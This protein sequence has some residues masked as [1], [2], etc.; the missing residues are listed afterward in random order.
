MSTERLFVEGIEDTNG[1][2][3]VPDPA[4]ADAIL[5]RLE[6][7]FE[8][9]RGTIIGEYFHGGTLVFPPQTIKRLAA[10]AAQAPLYMSVFLE[11]PA[12]IGP[13]V[14]LGATVIG[15]FGASDGVVLDAFRGR[16][17][18]SGRLPFDIPSSMEAAE[19]S[20][21]DVPFDTAA[22]GFHTGFGLT[23]GKRT[24]DPGSLV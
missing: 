12:I 24:A 15:E 7:L 9:G 13:P 4:D 10:Y 18:L 6:T 22:P 14:D 21:E 11:R 2:E 19:A 8:K 23:R 3:S 17:S 20:R 1:F 5:V 16:L